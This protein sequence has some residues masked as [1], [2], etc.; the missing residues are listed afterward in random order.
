MKWDDDFRAY[1]KKLEEK[2]PVI[3]CGDLNVAHKDHC[4]LFYIGM[5]ENESLEVIYC[6]TYK[7]CL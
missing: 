7:L 1:L 4:L 6:I 3:V 2:K 5:R